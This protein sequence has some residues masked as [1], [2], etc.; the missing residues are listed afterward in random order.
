MARE[1][2]PCPAIRKCGGTK[3]DLNA[4][5]YDS[6]MDNVM[7]SSDSAHY[8]AVHSSLAVPQLGSPAVFPAE[9]PSRALSAS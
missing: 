1:L 4:R 9:T 6:C 7:E 5:E 8:C 3:D 2:D